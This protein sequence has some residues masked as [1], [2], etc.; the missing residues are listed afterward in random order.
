MSFRVDDLL[1]NLDPGSPLGAPSDWPPVL[2]T[3]FGIMIASPLQTVLFWGPEYVALYNQAYAPTIGQKHPHA[4]G[5]PASEYWSE[6][7]DDL[8]PL[9]DQVR[10]QGD[11]VFMRDRPFYIERHG[12]PEVVTFDISY[13]P[14]PDEAGRTAGVLCVVNETTERTAYETRL[15]ESEERFRNMADSAPVMLWVVD[16]EGRCTYLNTRWYEYTGQTPEEAEGFGWLEVTHPDDRD[17][18]S[19]V[20]LDALS[21][22]EPFRLEYRLRRADG[23]YRWAIDAAEPRLAGDGSFLGYIGS[24]IDID[25]RHE[26]ERKLW[27]SE[28]GLRALTNSVDQMIWSTTPDGFHDYYNDRWYEFTGVPAGSTDGDAWNGIFHPDDR[29]RAWSIWQECLMTGRPYHIEYRLRHNTGVYRWV[30]GRANPV[31]DAAGNI[32]RWYGTC[33]DVHELKTAE[34]RRSALL[35]FD[36]TA[37]IL[38]N[39]DQ[40]AFAACEMVGVNLAASRVAY[41]LARSDEGSGFSSAKE[42]ISPSTADLEGELPDLELF[43]EQLERGETVVV[44]DLRED[45]RTRYQEFRLQV[46][47]VGSVVAVPLRN[48]NDLAAIFAV[49]DAEPARWPEEDLAFIRDV[50]VRVYNAV[51]RKRAEKNLLELMV[52]LE[53]QVTRRT[54][55]L[56]QSEERLRQSQKLETIGKLTGGV[57]HDFNNLLQVVAGNLQLLAKDVIGNAKA[58][59]RVTNA[60]AGVSR[61][62]KLA[63]QLLAFGRRQPLDPKVI[64]I[65]RFVRDMDDMLRRSI[66]EAIEIETVVAG[67]LWNCLADPAQVENAVLNLAINARDAMAGHGRLTIELGN[68]YLDDDYASRHE[69]VEPGQYVVLSV[70]DTGSGIPADML[71]LVIEPFF[72][73]KPEGKGTGLGLSMVFGFA[74]QSGG[75]V[76]IYSEV[77]HGTTVKMYLPRAIASEDREVV[78]QSGPIPGGSETILVAEDDDEVRDTVVE[79]LTDLGYKVLKAPNADAA[80]VIV[81][82]GIP[83][84]LLF[85]DVVMPGLMKSPELARRA[86]ERQPDIAVLYTSGYTENSIVHGGRLDAGVE[87]LSKPYT[88]EALARKVRQVLAGRSPRSDASGSPVAKT[89]RILRILF[90]EDDEQIRENTS[91]MLRSLGHAVRSTSL[92]RGAIEL[93]QTEE[94][95]L[96]IID[97]PLMET[98]GA[99]LAARLAARHPDLRLILASGNGLVDRAPVDAITVAKPYSSLELERALRQVMDS[100]P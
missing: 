71:D 3:T 5:R 75:H 26:V 97:L 23:I 85:T 1:R 19:Q 55:Q 92:E 14:V 49:H 82:A 27:E 40:I 35:A 28:A 13:S 22:Q 29:E 99:E 94:L 33:T 70:T 34:L 65:G 37:A 87:L 74:K 59:R 67:G 9:L 11:P 43:R 62:A 56:R 81:E 88:R 89:P 60:M 48:Q 73:T 68:A 44:R 80:L 45:H 58:E 47:P 57:A 51:E 30:I 36:E 84:D 7:W 77:G 25:D 6:L 93:A 2:K 61:G 96:L 15:R 90:V 100:R 16:K 50:A 72:S 12:R 86:R 42:W 63:S 4:F 17:M 39:P 95:D 66:G 24:V 98:G 31:S 18:A 32:V 20:F 46:H 91:E 21:R 64:N 53:E 76:K 41:V 54:E 10:D 79:T 38:D 52:S 69:E 83:I 8:R 78:V